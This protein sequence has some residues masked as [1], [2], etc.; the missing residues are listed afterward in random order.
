MSQKLKSITIDGQKFEI[1]AGGTTAQLF[2]EVVNVVAPANGQ[3]NLTQYNYKTI[4]LDITEL[5]GNPSL[6][7]TLPK[8]CIVNFVNGGEADGNLD[9]V[10]GNNYN[11]INGYKFST[12]SGVEA[13]LTSGGVINF[14]L[15]MIKNIILRMDY[16]IQ[17]NAS[18][19][20]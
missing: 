13:S 11:G 8:F 9:L 17:L 6:I 4:I 14:S 5:D 10:I 16:F 19:E 12:L 1:D 7:L 20:L 2:S 15:D 18:E 3:V